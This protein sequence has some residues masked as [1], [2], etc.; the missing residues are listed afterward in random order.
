MHRP[1]IREKQQPA[2]RLTL[3]DLQNK[4]CSSPSSSATSLLHT[5]SPEPP[6]PP[7]Q[8]TQPEFSLANITVPLESI[9][10]SESDGGVV[11]SGWAG[12][13]RCPAAPPPLELFLGTGGETGRSQSCHCLTARSS[14]KTFP[15]P[16]SQCPHLWLQNCCIKSGVT[17]ARGLLIGGPGAPSSLRQDQDTEVWGLP[18]IT[19]PNQ[20]WVSPTQEHRG[21]AGSAWPCTD[22]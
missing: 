11:G 13:V 15:L 17:Q 14:G 2:P 9:K 5:V 6:G 7:Q 8:P 18:Q 1:P 20:V 19:K 3:R 21:P 4:S 10:P 16:S 22:R 12:S